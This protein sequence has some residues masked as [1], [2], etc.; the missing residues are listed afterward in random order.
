MAMPIILPNM[1][2]VALTELM[3]TSTTRL[4]F[5]SITDDITMP[6]NTAMNM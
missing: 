1:S 2:S 3:S 5:S 4:D 6:P